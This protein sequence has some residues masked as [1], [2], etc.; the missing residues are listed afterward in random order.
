MITLNKDTN[1]SKNQEQKEMLCQYP[2]CTTKFIG[3][4]KRKYCDEHRKDKYK[5]NLYRK[6]MKKIGDNTYIKHNNDECIL[7]IKK[8]GLKHCDNEF[9]IKLIPNQYI[10]PKYCEEHRNKFK[11]DNFIKRN[12]NETT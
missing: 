11:R 1:R 3:R 4:G 10:Y 5:K 2:G 12:N 8:C 9:E 6:E 7:I